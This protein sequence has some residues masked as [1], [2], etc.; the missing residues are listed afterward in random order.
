MNA[1][2]A[3]AEVFGTAVLVLVSVGTAVLAGGFLGGSTLGVALAFGL[4]LMVLAYAIGHVSGC[5]VNPAVTVGMWL[6]GK[7][8]RKE[9]PL[10]IVSQVLGA[11]LGAAILLIIANG[12]DG[13]SIDNNVAGA[14][15]ANGYDDLSPGGYNLLAAAMSEVV[16][17][18]IF[19]FVVL[20]TTTRR[21]PAAAAGI[22]AGFALAIVH[23]VSIPVTNTSVNPA[24]SIATN[25]FAGGDYIPQLWLFIVAPVVG[26]ILA[27]LLFRFLNPDEFAGHVEPLDPT[28]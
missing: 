25:V 14:F 22:A 9:V 3:I 8:D 7:M 11:L 16:F 5:H 2:K 24:R 6:S 15:G 18:M 28:S 17:T 13:F 27:A 1:N 21:F 12:T 26:G 10:Y 23:L 4:T 19:V 20:G